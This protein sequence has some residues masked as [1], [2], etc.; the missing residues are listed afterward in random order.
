MKTALI[1]PPPASPTY[2]PY[3]TA[4]LIG[5]LSRIGPEV[6][7]SC[8]DL[9]IEAWKELSASLPQS[10]E[11]WRFMR[12]FGGNFTNREV[13]DSH[14]GVWNLIHGLVERAGHAATE[15]AGNG[16]RDEWFTGL[17]DRLLFP[18]LS[19]NPDSLCFSTVYLDQVPM[20]LALAER[21]L[22]MAGWSGSGP[23]PF[24]IFFGG[25]AMTAC[26]TSALAAGFPFVDLFHRGEGETVFGGIASG[27]MDP[28]GPTV[29]H[30]DLGSADFRKLPMGSYAN[31]TPIL[32]ITMSRNCRWGLCGFCA[33]NFSFG[34]YAERTIEQVCDEMEEGILRHGARHFYFV[35]QYVPAKRLSDLSGEISRR[36]LRVSFHVMARPT[37][38]YDAA[39]LSE[40]H[41]AGCRWISWGVESGSQRLLDLCRKGT[42]A[43]D[44]GR[45][46]R[47]S[48]EAGISNLL[49]MLFGLPTSTDA[50]LDET[51]IFLEDN[52]PLID[53]M[54]ASS[55]LLFD[56][57]MFASRASAYGLFSGSRQVMFTRNGI[58]V[59]S[60]RIDFRTAG[61][62]N[63]PVMPR[64][65]MEVGAWKSRRRWLGEPSFLETLPCE[66]YLLFAASK[67]ADPAGSPGK[68]AELA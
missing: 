41:D 55:F 62:G 20:A 27:N 67:E 63:H 21:A 53:A 10:A 37:R 28:T 9:N 23:R 19:T 16:L 39:V 58:P 2:V 64:G 61:E 7:V 17:L 51:F 36:G 48:S 22:E 40:A 32:P 46:L 68:P 8:H 6:A 38:D 52:Y 18:V 59:T 31:P 33:H 12:G 57:T 1:F 26:D 45:I 35:D 65:P 34:P 44:F 29:G 42:R 54:T 60:S 11:F 24:R 13:Y 15:S 14:R 49:M 5:H 25:S 50:D 4:M 56:G 43:S 3:G 30:R 47:D 66:H